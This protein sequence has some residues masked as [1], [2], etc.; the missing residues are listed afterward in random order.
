MILEEHIKAALGG[1]ATAVFAPAVPTA[2]HERRARRLHAKNPE[3]GEA[4]LFEVF[5]L[6][7]I[8]KARPSQ[9]LPIA[10][11]MRFAGASLFITG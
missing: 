2:S 10:G 1:T 4:S 11:A 9:I 6:R 7:V 5:Y 8:D 3:V